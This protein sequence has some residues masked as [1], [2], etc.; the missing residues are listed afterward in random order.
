MAR[1]M[2]HAWGMTRVWHPISFNK[3]N[4]AEIFYSRIHTTCSKRN[5]RAEAAREVERIKAVEEPVVLEHRSH[6]AHLNNL[7]QHV[8]KM[9]T[10][11]VF[12]SEG[13]EN[14]G[15]GESTRGCVKKAPPHIRVRA[16]L[17]AFG[18]FS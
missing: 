4:T 1:T 8:I 5:A 9:G 6:D 13:R 15:D 2:R 11:F 7:S 14:S 16:V 3:N 12:T 18:V 10:L 17:A